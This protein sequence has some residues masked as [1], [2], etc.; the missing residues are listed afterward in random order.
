[1]RKPIQI[2][3]LLS[4]LL[5]A[6]GVHA[7]GLGKLSVQSSLGQ[8]LRAE[9]ELLS[10]QKDELQAISAKLAGMDAFRQARIDRNEALGSLRFAVDQRANGQPI[11]KIT[12]ASP[13]NEP[14]LDM[15]V[16]LNWASGRLLREYTI[17]LDPPAEL[18]AQAAA[19]AQPPVATPAPAKPAV[20]AEPPKPR[21]QV[22]EAAPAPTPPTRYGPVKPG[23]TLR[24]IASKVRQADASLEQTMVGL[25]QQNR[26]AFMGDNMNRL[27]KGRTL[28]VPDAAQVRAV[29]PQQAARTV[30]THAADWHAYRRQLAE[31]VMAEPAEAPAERPAAGKIA[32]KPE[33][34]PAAPSAPPQDVLKLSKGGP[35]AG[36]D[37]KT[38]EKLNALE[39]E[40]AAKSRALDD[41]QKRVSQLE[42]TVRDLQRLMELRAQEA[43]K[44]APAPAPA[45]TPA[46]AA[47]QVEA[48]AAPPVAAQPAPAPVVKPAAKPAPMPVPAVTE[49][50]GWLKTFFTNP[51]Y[52]GGIIAAILLSALLWMMMVGTR[53]KQGLT[54]FE[55][56]IMTG[57]EFKHEAVF[58]TGGTSAAGAPTE[59]S[60]L[61]TDFSRLGLGSIDTHE[62]DPI[63]EA[64]VYM[65]YGR[66]AQAEEILKE[67]LHKDPSRHEITLK[68]LEIYASRK[69]TVAFET[70]AS[71]LYAALGGQATPLWQKAAEMG[72][73][74]DPENPLYR[75]SPDMGLPAAAATLA[76][77]AAA[78]TY[79]PAPEAAPTMEPAAQDLLA[80]PLD[81]GDLGDLEAAMPPMSEP[82]A[83]VSPAGPDN[84]MDFTSDLGLAEAAPETKA[85]PSWFEPLLE[86]LQSTP[87]EPAPAAMPEPAAKAPGALG[88]EAD[89]DMGAG[90]EWTEKIL[91]APAPEPVMPEGMEEITAAPAPEPVQEI[92]D[93]AGAMDFQVAE[94]PQ[95]PAQTIAEE[96]VPEFSLE[97]FQEAPE[98]PGN[99]P[100][101]LDAA[102]KG[103]PELPEIDLGGIDLELT[104]PLVERA[105][106]AKPLETTLDPDLWEEVNTKLD[107]ARAYLEMG[108]KEGAREI[109]QEVINEGD[110]NQK[111]DASLLM[112]QCA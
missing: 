59:G 72:R 49:E 26:D 19:Q 15:L 107:L 57:G 50:S 62:V 93:L 2:S 45:P 24:G 63:A 5:L 18:R 69:D 14:F 8:P 86:S 35:G 81:L 109:L 91:E 89:L 101:S 30:R 9:I 78:A 25:F 96:T 54:S 70:Q 105:V 58:K 27:K 84:T 47:P 12:S 31:Q 33:A 6:G 100:V 29:A 44:P 52:I 87:P 65:A 83:T 37:A 73:G 80:K 66:D 23:E 85:E 112:A 43:A 64:E 94:S 110:S 99:V 22:P 40:L 90:L 60:M 79:T 36:P 106:E 13:V 56:S 42:T 82:A 46:P 77:G 51:I 61:L 92:T 16:E 4:V 88:L 17:L 53:R 10:V 71:E 67:A 48:P 74:I 7:A 28:S 104:E 39:E 32:P 41:A 34:K 1:M 111:G 97:D 21:T 76:V 75:I 95:A 68:L 98:L 38:L 103:A 3:G 20:S 11:I 108:D 102:I 55:D